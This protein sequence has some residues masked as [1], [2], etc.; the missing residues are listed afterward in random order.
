MRLLILLHIGSLQA[1]EQCVNSDGVARCDVDCNNALLKCQTDCCDDFNCVSACN[2]ELVKCK[3]SCPC[4]AVDC[5]NG[6]PCANI[7]CS[8]F[9]V[10]IDGF[11]TVKG[12]EDEVHNEVVKFLGVPY[13]E[14]SQRFAASVMKKSLGEE[15][16]DATRFGDGCIGSTLA[17]WRSED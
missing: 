9:I 14:V 16:F 17:N 6:C 2:R 1:D 11:G 13:A 5:L 8:T 15:I 3:D 10:D 7:Y 12:Q 4:R